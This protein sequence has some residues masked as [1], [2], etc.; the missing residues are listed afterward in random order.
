MKKQ[1]LI[2]AAVAVLSTGCAGTTIQDQI[3]ASSE[4]RALER[5]ADN[6][7]HKAS[8]GNCSIIK[9]GGFFMTT[10]SVSISCP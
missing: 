5:M 9:T 3:S 4:G 10:S 2:I 8:T 6:L 1:I 7:S